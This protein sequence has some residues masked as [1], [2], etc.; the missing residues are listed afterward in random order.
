MHTT[1]PSLIDC[2][3]RSRDPA[4]WDRFVKLYSAGIYSWARAM[5]LQHA[6]AADL[7]QDV[8]AVLLTKLPD[9]ERDAN[10]TFRGWLWTITRNKYLERVR[11]AKVNVVDDVALEEIAV[12]EEEPFW[13]EDFRRH[14]VA[15]IVESL[16]SNFPP[17]VWKAF[18]AH[19][20]DGKTAAVVAAELDINLWAV[21]TSK[22]RVFEY[23]N[24]EFPD[25][26]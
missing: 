18:L 11:R 8:F 22:M 26:V 1:S 12:E 9:F 4:A 5:R 10:G 23:L 17:K 19:V 20:M 7:V 3:R 21:Y 14:L 15:R 13:E 24:K 6:D 16:Q 2:L 25:L